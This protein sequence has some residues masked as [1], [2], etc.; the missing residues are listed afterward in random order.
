MTEL[1][2][3]FFGGWGFAGL[4]VAIELWRP[5]TFSKL[6]RA[7]RRKLQREWQHIQIARARRE[8]LRDETNWF[9]GQR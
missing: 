4:C 7:Q 9:R 8:Y 6:S 3:L 5:G 2:Q 1:L